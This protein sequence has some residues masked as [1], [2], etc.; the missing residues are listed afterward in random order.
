MPLLDHQKRETMNK[1]SFDLTKHW[2]QQIETCKQTLGMLHLISNIFGRSF[3]EDAKTKEAYNQLNSFIHE[4]ELA[5]WR[6][7]FMF[8]LTLS[9]EQQKKIKALAYK[10]FMESK[11]AIMYL[12][13]DIGEHQFSGAY[14]VKE[15]NELKQYLAE[16]FGEEDVEPGK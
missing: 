16:H 13:D 7:V 6:N 12:L 3:F 11:N 8:A 15:E 9:T 10:R 14:T 5:A 1:N 4:K 2:L